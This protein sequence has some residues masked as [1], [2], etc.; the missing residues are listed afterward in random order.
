[1][2]GCRYVAASD[3]TTCPLGIQPQRNLAQELPCLWKLFTHWCC[4]R[5]S[6]SLSARNVSLNHLHS[7]ILL[8]SR[9]QA[10]LHRQKYVYNFA[11]CGNPLNVT[12]RFKQLPWIGT[13]INS[14]LP[15]L[16][17]LHSC[18]SPYGILIRNVMKIHRM[19]R[20][21]QKTTNDNHVQSSR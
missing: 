10:I 20:C 7:C 13:V 16:S 14:N 3:V 9:N 11:L 15:T 19:K 8:Q 6:L 4:W 12:D 21:N 5:I 1:M 17:S 18:D 2:N